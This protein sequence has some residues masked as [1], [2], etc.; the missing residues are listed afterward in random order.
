MAAIGKHFVVT[1]ANGVLVD[2]PDLSSVEDQPNGSIK[3]FDTE[4]LCV[5]TYGP[6]GY[7]SY[8][9]VRDEIREGYGG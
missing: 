9:E 4:G 3:L 5:R 8:Y 7:Q 1:S 6:N 2:Y